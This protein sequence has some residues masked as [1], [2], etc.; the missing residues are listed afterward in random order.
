MYTPIIFGREYHF[1]IGHNK[2]INKSVNKVITQETNIL[3][4]YIYIKINK[5]IFIQYA[6]RNW[7]NL[8]CWGFNS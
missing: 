6:Y 2:T 1:Q 7:N 5:V 3:G 4:Y 8:Q